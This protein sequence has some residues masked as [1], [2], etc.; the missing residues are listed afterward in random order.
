MSH[1]TPAGRAEVGQA[2]DLRSTP[3]ESLALARLVVDTPRLAQQP[4]GGSPALPVH[5]LA[6]LVATI[7]QR[8][9]QL[10]AFR[11]AAHATVYGTTPMYRAD[12]VDELR[13][14][15]AVQ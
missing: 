11:A 12:G 3:A 5:H 13:R 10:G 1:P 6:Q 15:L 7:D 4:A 9:D 14:L 2:E 8:T